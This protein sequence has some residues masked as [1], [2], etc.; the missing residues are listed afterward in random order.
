MKG[1]NGL[2]RDDSVHFLISSAP[3][4]LFHSYWKEVGLVKGREFVHHTVMDRVE[5]IQALI[6]M[7]P[8]M[9]TLQKWSKISISV[10]CSR[11]KIP[12]TTSEA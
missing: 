2:N 7:F 8:G 6:Q 1:N 4:K 11:D 3:G 9:K 12:F 10:H 5:G